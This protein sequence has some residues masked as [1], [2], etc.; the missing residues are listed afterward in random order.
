MEDFL[1]RKSQGENG[2]GR[3]YDEYEHFIFIFR[4]A[5]AAYGSSQASLKLCPKILLQNLYSPFTQIVVES[6]LARLA[7]Q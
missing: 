5:L 7:T 1:G 6:K 4:A 3:I 2:N